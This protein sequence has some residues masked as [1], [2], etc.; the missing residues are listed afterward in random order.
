MASMKMKLMMFVVATLLAGPSWGAVF[1][2]DEAGLDAAIA[3]AEDAMSP[4]PGPHTFSCAGPSII[5]V[6]TT[7]FVRSD[8]HS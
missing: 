8:I 2:C 7:K 6:T 3:A 4:D 5:P 1:S